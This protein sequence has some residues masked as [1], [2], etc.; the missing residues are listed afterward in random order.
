MMSSDGLDEHLQLNVEAGLLFWPRPLA[1]LHRDVFRCSVPPS[2]YS[3]NFTGSQTHTAVPSMS[4][5]PPQE[6][7]PEAKSLCGSNQLITSAPIDS[8]VNQY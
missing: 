1:T 3:G 6:V 7:E 5:T 4:P 2:S 8:D